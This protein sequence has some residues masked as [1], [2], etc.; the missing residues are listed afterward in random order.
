MKTIGW[1]VLFSSAIL[2]VMTE[3]S[4]QAKVDPLIVLDVRARW[5]CYQIKRGIP[6][7]VS[8]K[9]ISSDR[10]LIYQNKGKPPLGLRVFVYNAQ[11]ELL[12]ER[13]PIAKKWLS[14]KTQDFI[15]IKP[16][17]ESI[18]KTEF[19]LMN[20]GIDKPGEYWLQA[21]YRSPVFDRTVP[22]DIKK[23][24]ILTTRDKDLISERFKVVVK[25]DC[26]N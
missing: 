20:R 23:M 4:G 16:A 2:A 24:K 8:F 6:V 12:G 25:N 17:D 14:P 9:N 13:N 3:V 5:P 10:I 18:E 21:V 26:S 19:R 1:L 7:T 11:N 22:D 15:E